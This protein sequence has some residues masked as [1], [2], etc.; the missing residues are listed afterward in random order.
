MDR[1][2]DVEETRVHFLARPR[3]AHAVLRHLETGGRDAAG[4]RR[5]PGTEKNLRLEELIH[6]VDRGRHV[7][8]FRD[9]VD[10]VPQEIGRVLA[11]DLILRRARKRALRLVIPKRIVIE[12]RIEPA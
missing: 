3:N 2:H 11:V 5:L 8:A 4:V 12:L 1:L 10:A 7:R 9:D 6:A